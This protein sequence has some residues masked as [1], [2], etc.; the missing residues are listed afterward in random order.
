MARVL[1]PA[2]CSAV[3]DYRG[4][5]KLSDAKINAIKG[6]SGNVDPYIVHSFKSYTKI[7]GVHSPDCVGYVTKSCTWNSGGWASGCPNARSRGG[8]RCSVNQQTDSYRGV[9]G[10]TCSNDGN[11][12]M[13]FEHSAR[14][15]FA[16]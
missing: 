1:I 9:D 4:Y 8:G 5:C 14:Q 11:Y 10:H 13:I 7:F 6:T 16:E 3:Q 15:D 12:F 2:E